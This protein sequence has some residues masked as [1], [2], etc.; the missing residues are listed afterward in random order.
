MSVRFEAQKKINFFYVSTII[1]QQMLWGELVMIALVLDHM[2][3]KYH[4]SS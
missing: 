4:D 2:S 3:E 1:N